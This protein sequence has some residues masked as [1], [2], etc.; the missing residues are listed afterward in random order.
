MASSIPTEN[1]TGTPLSTAYVPSP[2]AIRGLKVVIPFDPTSISIVDGGGG[3]GGG[4]GIGG[5]GGLGNEDIQSLHTPPI[6]E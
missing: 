6:V 1:A 4:G 5:G 3:G 2:E